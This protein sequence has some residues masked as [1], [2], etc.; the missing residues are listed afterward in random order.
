MNMM[1]QLLLQLE[2]EWV[3]ARYIIMLKENMLYTKGHIVFI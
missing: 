3:L 2:M 1:K